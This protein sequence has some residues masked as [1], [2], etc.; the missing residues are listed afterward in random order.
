MLDRISKAEIAFSSQN[1]GKFGEIPALI[2][3]GFLPKDV[4]DIRIDGLSI[5]RKARRT[6]DEVF[7]DGRSGG[8]RKNRNPFISGAFKRQ[9]RPRF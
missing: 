8:I 4:L 7:G 2:D 9:P 1:Q 6:T 3:A 5:R